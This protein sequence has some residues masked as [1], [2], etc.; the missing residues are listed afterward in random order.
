MSFSAVVSSISPYKLKCKNNFLDF[1]RSTASLDP[2]YC[3]GSAKDLKLISKTVDNSLIWN[4][5]IL[6]GMLLKNNVQHGFK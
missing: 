5:Y 4:H 2:W 1:C 6:N 3:N